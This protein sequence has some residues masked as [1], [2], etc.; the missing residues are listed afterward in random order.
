M[1]NKIIEINNLTVD[2]KSKD[3]VFRAVNNIS[4]DISK[5][6]TVAL[7]GESGSGKSVTALSI[8]QLLPKHSSYYSDKSSIVFEKRNLIGMEL[9]SIR[10]IRGSSISMIF[11]E[12]MT[13]LNP[14][15]RVGD[16]IDES[17][18]IHKGLSKRD[19]RI[20][21]IN[22]LEQVNIPSAKEK[23]NSFP[24]E[25]SGGQR[26]RVMIAMALANEPKL[27]IADEPTT[28]LDV[29]VEKSLLELLGELQDNLGMSILF[30]THDLN[31]VRKFASRVNVMQRGE[32]VEK[33]RVEEVFTNPVH[34]YTK[35]LIDSIPKE[36]QELT[37]TNTP[38]L[39]AKEVNVNY[40]LKK[41][42]FKQDTYLNA[43]KD[44]NINVYPGSTTGLVGESGSGKSSLA[45]ALLGLEA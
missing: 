36:K 28:A 13:S 16:Q 25:L 33:G 14:Y 43:V 12:P 2:F 27:L 21:T 39:K 31:I 20:R 11:Q 8:L 23:S 10:R 41:S 15:Q 26:Q 18:I 3:Q 7:V 35:K 42:F 30:I 32:I 34:Q 22:L 38:L 29:T 40:L 4:F 45:R 24:H 17:L 6:E 9:K 1:E 37:I 44:V 19:A 5:G